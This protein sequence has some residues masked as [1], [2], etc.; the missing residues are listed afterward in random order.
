MSDGKSHW[1]RIYTTKAP[2]EVSWFQPEPVASMR[3]I[4]AAG[5]QPAT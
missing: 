2:D 5:V 1:E 4:E 3:L